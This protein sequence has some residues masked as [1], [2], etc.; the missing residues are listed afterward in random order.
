MEPPPETLDEGEEEPLVEDDVPSTINIEDMLM[1]YFLDADGNGIDLLGDNLSPDFDLATIDKLIFIVNE[2][3]MDRP[4]IL[5][6]NL[7]RELNR[8]KSLQLKRR[9]SKIKIQDFRID[10][11]SVRNAITPP[12]LAILLDLFQCFEESLETVVH[13]KFFGIHP[14]SRVHCTTEELTTWCK[15]IKNKMPF[16]STWLWDGDF[17]I[18]DDVCC[19]C[20]DVIRFRSKS[21]FISE[22]SESSDEEV[23][24]DDEQEIPQCRCDV[25]ANRVNPVRDLLKA[26]FS[27][28]CIKIEIKSMESSRG[29]TEEINKMAAEDLVGNT[30]LRIC[31]LGQEG[32]ARALF[33]VHAPIKICCLSNQKARDLH[34]DKEQIPVM[35]IVDLMSTT[36]SPMTY[37]EEPFE[38]A[39][40]YCSPWYDC[41]E[42]HMNCNFESIYHL[43]K[44]NVETLFVANDRGN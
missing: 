21:R 13:F 28:S 23:K 33:D 10:F 42:D 34:C 43:V 18:T 6:E 8:L 22:S 26:L 2:H 38:F 3:K 31:V 14:H 29:M 17:E 19:Q 39:G 20:S 35:D 4:L 12:R 44:N 7:E 40:E 1:L 11:E 15:V 16:L 30:F 27:K 36:Q 25:V 24:L 37:T 5:K 32:K 41:M 9:G